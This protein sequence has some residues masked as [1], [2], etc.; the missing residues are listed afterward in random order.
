V[1]FFRSNYVILFFIAGGLF[2]LLDFIAIIITSLNLSFLTMPLI[3]EIFKSISLSINPICGVFF[4]SIFGIAE[5]LSYIFKFKQTIILSGL[6]KGRT[7]AF[8]FHFFLLGIQYIGW[9]KYRETIKK[10]YIFKYLALAIYLH[11]MWNIV[12]TRF[13]VLLIS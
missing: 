6:I 13:I 3:E 5:G 11:Y 9:K 10:Y 2:Y 12:I 7:L 8:L 1:Q 4:T